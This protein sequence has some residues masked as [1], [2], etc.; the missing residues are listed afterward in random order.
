M[1]C[2]SH[3]E[4]EDDLTRRDR[5]DLLNKYLEQRQGFLAEFERL[6]RGQRGRPGRGVVEQA[7]EVVR[8]VA[9]PVAAAVAGR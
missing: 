7:E 3:R 2:D 1:C 9:S 8:T 6:L 5:S 4:V